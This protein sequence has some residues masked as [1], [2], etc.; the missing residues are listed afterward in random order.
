MRGTSAIHSGIAIHRGRARSSAASPV[1][2]AWDSGVGKMAKGVMSQA[3][4]TAA[5][6]DA[7]IS[8]PPRP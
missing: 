7:R 3:T 4:N 1:E 8:C 6:L 2:A 5:L